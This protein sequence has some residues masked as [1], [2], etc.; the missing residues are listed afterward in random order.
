MFSLLHKNGKARRYFPGSNNRL[1]RDLV[2]RSE[3]FILKACLLSSYSLHP[4]HLPYQGASRLPYPGGGALGT[5][6][7]TGE[8]ECPLESK[9]YCY[10]YAK[11]IVQC[12]PSTFNFLKIVQPGRE[13][14]R[15]RG[16]L[17]W[18]SISL[19]DEGSQS[20]RL[21]LFSWTISAVYFGLTEASGC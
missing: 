5:A 17:T 3:I 11:V 16:H 6:G 18:E 20:S 12:L 4:A 9:L 1:K 21:H 13:N 7:N 15:T 8:E 10:V 19:T 14:K 2:E